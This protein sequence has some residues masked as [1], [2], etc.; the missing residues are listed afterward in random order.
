MLDYLQLKTEFGNM[1]WVFNTLIT[2]ISM[3]LFY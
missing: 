3:F 2:I 1:Q